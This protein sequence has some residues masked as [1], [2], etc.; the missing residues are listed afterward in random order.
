MKIAIT[1]PTGHIGSRLVD[2]LLSKGGHELVLLCRDPAKVKHFTDRGA[3]AAAGSLEDSQYV[4][5]ATKGADLLFWLTPPRFDAEDFRAYQNQLGDIAA[6]TV[7]ENGIKRVVHLSSFGAQH[8]DGTGPIA[9]LHDIEQKLNAAAKDVGG[10]VTH[11]R[12]ASFFENLFMSVPTIQS[13][14][15]MYMP[16]PGDLAFPMIA[17]SDI[18]KVAAEVISDGSW[19]GV[20]VR[21]LLGPKD[22]SINDAARIIGEVAGKEVK[23]VQVPYEATLEAMKGMGLSESLASKYV[24]M[25]QGLENG[26]VSA[27]APRS[28]ASTTPTKLEDF[29]KQYIAPA[30]KG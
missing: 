14:G 11:L 15:A 21:E 30:L 20:N 18:A 9:G 22:Y 24:E 25:Y 4:G 16:I 28:A 23:H 7:R 8:A 29:A 26:K 10:S 5:E 19:Q 1:T 3:K 13:D 27:E 17:T 6:A 2:E 12:P